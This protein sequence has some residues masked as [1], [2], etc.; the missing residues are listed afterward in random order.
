MT[1]CT[2]GRQNKTHCLETQTVSH[3]AASA[4]HV[5]SVQITPLI[6][7]DDGML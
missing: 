5:A 7:T 3:L 6:S 4:S 1:W 2:A